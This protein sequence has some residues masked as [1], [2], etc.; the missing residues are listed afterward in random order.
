MGRVH[1]K[2]SQPPHQQINPESKMQW[3]FKDRKRDKPT[4]VPHHDR[5]CG[6]SVLGLLKVT[7][8][9]AK[10]KKAGNYNVTLSMGMQV[11]GTL[12][13]SP[14]GISAFWIPDASGNLISVLW[15]RISDAGSQ[16]KV[17]ISLLFS[18][19]YHQIFTC[20]CS[21]YSKHCLKTFFFNMFSGH[22]VLC[23]SLNIISGR[24]FF[25]LQVY[26]YIETKVRLGLELLMCRLV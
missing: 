12:S 16:K 23:V 24:T 7:I 10:L 20:R 11:S 2:P 14:V 13:T 18:M 15:S 26:K 8:G 5:I 1:S 21:A 17:Q 9:K 3:V 25:Y 4:K 22:T 19:W 6:T